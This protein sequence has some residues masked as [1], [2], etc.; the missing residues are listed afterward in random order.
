MEDGEDFEDRARLERAY[1]A[2]R[3]TATREGVTIGIRIGEVCAVLDAWLGAAHAQE[4]AYLTA[5][6]P[7]SRVLSAE[8]NAARMAALVVDL[9]VIG[10]P[11]VHGAGEPAPAAD[12]QVDWT[13][14]PSVLVLGLSRE[15]ALELARRYDQHA[16]V[17]GRRGQAAELIWT[18]HH[19]GVM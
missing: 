11:M 1:R 5:C 12:G 9:G 15:A 2:T 16:F 10:W 7:R 14:E 3:Y 8:Q 19:D 6:N 18:T 13:A 17:Y 4:W